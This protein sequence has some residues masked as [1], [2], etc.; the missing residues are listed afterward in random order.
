MDDLLLLDIASNENRVCEVPSRGTSIEHADL[1]RLLRRRGHGRLMQ[2][3]ATAILKLRD[4]TGS[5]EKLPMLVGLDLLV[6][7]KRGDRFAASEKRVAGPCRTRRRYR[8]VDVRRGA[9]RC[10]CRSSGAKASSDVRRRLDERRGCRVRVSRSTRKRDRNA[11]S[12]VTTW[13][14]SSRKMNSVSA[15]SIA[16]L[17]PT[18]TPTSCWSRLMTVQ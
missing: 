8:F 13:S 6:P 10:V 17:R 9:S 14:S 12:A 3:V 7:T 4:V 11:G 18:P 1:G 2:S 5:V 15:A 16:A